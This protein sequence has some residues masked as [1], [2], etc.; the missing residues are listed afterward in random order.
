MNV[1]ELRIGNLV[2]D[3]YQ[4]QIREVV[5][6]SDYE[7]ELFHTNIRDYK[8]RTEILKPIPLTEEWLL[9]FGFVKDPMHYWEIPKNEFITILQEDYDD[10]ILFHPIKLNGI[11]EKGVNLKY[12]H[13]LQNIYFSLTNEELTIKN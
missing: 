3:K 8:V 4:N 6:I 10:C 13:Q 11:V 9:R 7:C 5:S 12:V 1:K 2:S